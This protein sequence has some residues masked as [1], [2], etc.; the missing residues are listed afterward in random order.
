MLRLYSVY[1]Y[2][3]PEDFAKISEVPGAPRNVNPALSITWLVSG[4]TIYCTIFN[5]NP[6]PPRQFLGDDILLKKSARGNAHRT[7]Y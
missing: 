1:T 4:T 2:C 7:N 3:W 5:N 6:P